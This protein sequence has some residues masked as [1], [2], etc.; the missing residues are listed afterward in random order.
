MYYCFLRYQGTKLAGDR[1]IERLKTEVMDTC[2]DKIVGRRLMALASP[3][4]GTISPFCSSKL[5]VEGRRDGKADKVMEGELN[6][7]M[8]LKF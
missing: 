3:S 8:R 7:G 2:V 4:P 5:P 6:K 1:G